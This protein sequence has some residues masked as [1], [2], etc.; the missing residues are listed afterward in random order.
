LAVP[1][2]RKI[3]KEEAMKHALLVMVLVIGVLA[4]FGAMSQ[5]APAPPIDMETMEL[6]L[7]LD[8]ASAPEVL[9]VGVSAVAPAPS[10]YASLAQLAM[11]ESIST[12]TATMETCRAP[13]SKA[14]ASLVAPP[15]MR[16]EAGP[17]TAS[18]WVR[19][20][21]HAPC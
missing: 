9:D 19:P 16:R 1:Q 12:S 2:K 5:K 17:L 10:D 21:D 18:A 4:A 14:S 13:Q 20:R 7:G 15:C 6:S 3:R 11:I 8:G